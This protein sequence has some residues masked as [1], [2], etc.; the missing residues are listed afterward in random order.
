MRRKPIL[1]SICPIAL[2]VAIYFWKVVGVE[3]T[4]DESGAVKPADV[5]QVPGSATF[6]SSPDRLAAERPVDFLAECLAK[7]HEAGVKGY[8]CTFS[9]HERVNGRMREPDQI[10]C[11]FKEEPFSVMM[12]WKKGAGRAAASLYVLGE[13]GNEMCIRPEGKIQKAAVALA[14]GYVRRPV[15][16]PEA[17]DSSRYLIT[18]F[19]VRCGTERTYKAWKALQDRGVTLQVKYLGVQ[20]V[21]EAGG[22]ACHVIQRRCDP[23]EEE[24]LTEITIYVDAETWFQVGSVLKQ[25]D[26]LIG[27]YWFTD[28]KLNP[29]FDDNQFKPETLKKF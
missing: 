5:V 11:W 19:G 8:T 6:G 14:G 24:G 18:E 17:K 26:E 22:R 4:P 10:E 27:S 3:L 20:N 1:L 29:D 25:N 28:I 16:G 9:M 2:V 7:Y 13:N 23:P 21:E 12:H 15:N